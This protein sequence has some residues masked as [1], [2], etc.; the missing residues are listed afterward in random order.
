M[1]LRMNQSLSLTTT[2]TL[3]KKKGLESSQYVGLPLTYDTVFHSLGRSQVETDT[4]GGN[5]EMLGYHV[6]QTP[7]VIMS[8][9]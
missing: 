5:T 3:K 6:E 9:P 7:T 8:T 2:I 1:A 4:G